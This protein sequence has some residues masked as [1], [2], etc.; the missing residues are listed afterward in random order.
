VEIRGLVTVE[1]NIDPN[2]DVFEAFAIMQ[3]INRLK[4]KLEKV[5]KGNKTQ[6]GIKSVVEN[7]FKPNQMIITSDRLK[8]I[9]SLVKVGEKTTPAYQFYNYKLEQV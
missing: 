6:L 7:A 1:K 5:L 3:E 9:R 4:G 8:I 2:M